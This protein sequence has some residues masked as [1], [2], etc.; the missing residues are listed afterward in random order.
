MTTTETLK[1]ALEALKQID[2]AMPFPVA[3]LAQSAL[4]E[5][6]A[7]EA[8][9]QPAPVAKPH[10]Q[11]PFGYFRYDLRLDAWVQN[12]EGRPGT[13]FYTSP[14]QR[15]WVGLTDEEKAD[16]FEGT[17]PYYNE[18][19]YADAIEAKLKEKNT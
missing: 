14:P 11:E 9:E 12:R 19:D 15:P 18:T 10:E 8:I 3:K 17:A 7:S 16:L 13:A 1:L 4:R 5:A 2:E 6:L